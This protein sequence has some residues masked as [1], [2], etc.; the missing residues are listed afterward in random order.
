MIQHWEMKTSMMK[1]NSSFFSWHSWSM[2]LI[3]S[4][5]ALSAMLGIVQVVS[6][7]IYN[8]DQ[9]T[10]Y[11]EY[12]VPHSEFTGG[13][14][15][16]VDPATGQETSKAVA[17]CKDT[18][19]SGG[20]DYLEPWPK[21]DVDGVS[22][23][24]TLILA[25]PD[26]FSQAL[27]AEI[28]LDLWRNQNRLA[29]YKINDGPERRTTVGAKWSR[30]PYVVEIPLNELRQGDNT[31]TFTTA[32][33][34]YHINDIA[35]RIYFDD[36]HPLRDAGGVSI[37]APQGRLTQVSAGGQSFDPAVGGVLNVDDNQVTLTA[38]IDSPASFVEF[39]GYYE[40]Y[41]ED[42]DGI[43][44]DWH[45]RG[46]NNW[47]PGGT[48]EQAT[49]G[50][51]DHI[52]TAAISGTGAYSVTWDAKHI[53]SQSGVRF[54]TRIVQAVTETD[55]SQN[56]VVSDAAGGPS[57]P[58]TLKRN[59]AVMAFM[60]DDFT[61]NV[62]CHRDKVEN[63]VDVCRYPETREYDLTL[64]VDPGQFNRSYF[65]GSYWEKPQFAINDG[66]ASGVFASGQDKWTLGVKQISPAAYIQ[67]TNVISYVY[68]SGFGQFI[69]YPG[70]MVV[71]AQ[72]SNQADNK[73][74]TAA[75]TTPASTQNVP[76]DTN[77]VVA[78]SEMD[79]QLGS[80]VDRESIVMRVDGQ[81][82]TP[83]ISGFS[84]QYQVTYAPPQPL[85]YDADVQVEIEADDL[86]GNALSTASYAFHTQLQ[87][88]PLNAVSDDFNV[89]ALDENVWTWNDPQA[90]Q[91]GESSYRMTGS[92]LEID[93]PGGV[94]H[95]IWADGIQAPHLMQDVNNDPSFEIQVGF[96]SS[97]TARYQL[98]GILIQ[99]DANNFLRL[100]F[101]YDG[102]SASLLAAKMINGA[103]TKI[104][105]RTL[106]PA[107]GQ[108][109]M[110]MR[111]RRNNDSW[112]V[113]YSFDGF[114]W[115]TGA[116]F[117]FTHAMT[118]AQIGVFAGNAGDNPAFTA[119]V[120]YFFDMASPIAPQD[121]NILTF[122]DLQLSLASEPI[123]PPGFGQVSGGPASP[124]PGNPSC[125]S[126]LMLMAEPVPGWSFDHW[127]INTPSGN[128]ESF[129]NPLVRAFVAGESVQANFITASYDL[130]VRVVSNGQGEGA[131]VDIDPVKPVYYYSDTVTLTAQIELG[132]IFD[133]WSGDLPA[134]SDPL[135]PTLNLVMDSDKVITGTVTQEQ[136]MLTTTITGTGNG[137]V[138][139]QPPQDFYVY[140]DPV[141]L[142]AIPAMNGSN[143]GGWSGDLPADAD[144]LAL[145]LELFMD[146]DKSIQ[147]TFQL[148]FTLNT[149]VEGQGSILVDPQKDEYDP[150]ETVALT[151]EPAEG[152]AF[153]EWRGSLLG[154]KNPESLLMDGNK[155]VT[156]VFVEQPSGHNVYLPIVKR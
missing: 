46:R 143:F 127:V 52:G 83:Q 133:G 55:G 104:W 56:Y 47:H 23:K 33:G 137:I 99:Q 38:Q 126:P 29:I 3:A 58:F 42:N 19:A 110:R 71:M 4:L 30:T 117:D 130:D 64:P 131:K 63:G 149:Q 70:P 135:S 20:S 54:K 150:G 155:S 93:V 90:G 156:A 108:G 89:C 68:T 5:M 147:A 31:L 140:G 73:P 37:Q 53:P 87:D 66:S 75:L 22:C 10:T 36:A 76:V 118:V 49:G 59:R 103:P 27:R 153:L 94:S 2:V 79:G 50:T 60:I 39:H 7:G 11:K 1:K 125:G 138:A 121:V 69:E 51:I 111:V 142:T 120:D 91:A 61:D 34:G 18:K 100:N 97:L 65:V 134:A 44:R 129:D 113:A 95:D 136:Y 96:T 122:D 152:W 92:K 144:P 48:A 107:D 105:E 14:R 9:E 116:N 17:G 67:G 13:F 21:S 85:P 84:N 28:Y 24:K 151:A 41:D 57:Q 45:N 32:S 146:G 43:F 154:D 115:I 102:S 82:V 6:A 77:I 80:G 106:S 16:W 78:L 35:I 98:Q 62:L 88:V 124:T 114:D 123:S 74:P 141:T 12:W 72:T 81:T 128:I 148:G 86:A 109:P 40:G 119:S 101:Q 145:K 8:A 25:I 112:E 15:R 132:W 26:D 139:V